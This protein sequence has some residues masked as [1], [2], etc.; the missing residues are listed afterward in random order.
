MNVGELPFG[1][2]GAVTLTH[3]GSAVIIKQ[4]EKTIQL[5]AELEDHGC[6]VSNALTKMDRNQDSIKLYGFAVPVCHKIGLVKVPMNLLTDQEGKELSHVI[7]YRDRP[8]DASKQDRELKSVSGQQETD[9]MS[10]LKDQ[11]SK[12]KE[13]QDRGR[14]TVNQFHEDRIFKELELNIIAQ[15]DAEE[16]K[17]MAAREEGRQ[18][19]YVA[20]TISHVE[21]DFK[22]VQL[23]FVWMK[24]SSVMPR[25]RLLITD[26]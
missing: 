14:D 6:I 20:H 15:I 2:F 24:L 1:T 22:E 12:E 9:S 8:W 4:E 21:P 16:A 7:P 5:P 26:R 23:M 10:A 17:L 13:G 3:D 18:E 25:L 19:D 11:D